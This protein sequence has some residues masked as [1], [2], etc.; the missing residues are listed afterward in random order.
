MVAR[1]ERAAE[2]VLGTPLWN[3]PKDDGTLDPVASRATEDR[4]SISEAAEG[5][6]LR[7]EPRD[8][9]EGIGGGG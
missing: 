7:S 9:V 6:R 8:L 4:G 2:T 1:S 3:L 5:W